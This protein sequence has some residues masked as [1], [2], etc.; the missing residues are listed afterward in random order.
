MAGSTI[1]A[2]VGDKGPTGDIGPDGGQG[3]VGP[4]GPAGPGFESL[5]TPGDPNKG[6]GLIPWD[7]SLNYPA[8]T[9]GSGLNSLKVFMTM[10]EL[11]RSARAYGEVNVFS[12]MTA[13]QIA[14]VQGAAI[15]DHTAPITAAIN[16]A[17]AKLPCKVIFGKGTFN[18]TSL[19]NLAKTGLTI[20]GQG[21]RQTVLQCT[22]TTRALLVDAFASGSGTDPFAQDCN[23]LDFTLSGNANTAR[24]FDAQGLARSRIKVNFK[25]ATAT[26]GVAAHLKGCM[27]S[28]YSESMC[29][30][31]FNAMTSIPGTG[32]FMDEG[33][34][35][36]ISIGNSSNNL[37]LHTYWEGTGKG[38]DLVK[39]DQNNFMSGSPESTT[40]YG[41]VVGAGCRYN[42]FI[43]VG[44]ENVNA[45]ADIADA[46]IQTRFVNCYASKLTLLQGTQSLIEGG[47]HNSVTI[48]SGAV[49]NKV[50]GIRIRHWTTTGAF[51]D[52][53]TATE[54]GSIYDAQLN[55]FIY[56]KASR[57]SITVTASPFTWTNNLGQYVDF[58][59]QAGTLTQ[60]RQGDGTGD[61]WLIAPTTPQKI[62][63][64]PGDTIEL[65]YSSA[66]VA[67]RII[68]N[69]IPT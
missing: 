66:P 53:G 47:Y 59:I 38:V 12:Y 13:A 52:Q 5:T 43:G 45:T 29:S 50:T 6:P 69:S 8:N 19:P 63:L 56:P 64:R 65:S 22:G 49:K 24:L 11:E 39:A 1:W 4:M 31:D 18:Y 10:L 35:A 34:R 26:T 36:T 55:A 44:F 58:I 68:H 16:A 40:V 28:N 37:L 41:L 62:F 67:S 54:Y 46:G 14:D 51:L 42:T 23:F 30:T 32:L 17:I 57:T 21:F 48:Q 33:R 25:N 2:P 7:S 60:I 20:Q 3:P 61:L 9:V 15:G 27:L